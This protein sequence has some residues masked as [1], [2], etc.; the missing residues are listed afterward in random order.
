MWDYLCII[1]SK[2]RN[3]FVV[4]KSWL[5]N[6][7]WKRFKNGIF[8]MIWKSFLKARS[9]WLTIWVD[10]FR[11]FI[12]HISTDTAMSSKLI[13][14]SGI[15]LTMPSLDTLFFIISHDTTYTTRASTE[16]WGYVYTLSS[17]SIFLPSSS[18]Y[19]YLSPSS[20]PVSISPNLSLFLS[21][22]P[23]T[24]IYISLKM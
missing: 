13:P 4:F 20:S 5:W 7:M 6:F 15:P 19:I 10:H 24:Y 18:T 21:L 12:Y 23:P 22:L 11:R 3:L 1:L 9:D 14:R 2:P 17:R 16:M 8:E